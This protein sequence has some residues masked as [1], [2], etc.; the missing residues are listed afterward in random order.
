MAGVRHVDDV[1][2]MEDIDCFSE[3]RA[4]LLGAQ[5]ILVVLEGNRAGGSHQRECAGRERP[6]ILQP[7]L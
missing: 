7:A 4:G 1:L 5:A 2:A 6:G 3:S